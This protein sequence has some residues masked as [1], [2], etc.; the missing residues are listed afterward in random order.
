MAEEQVD[1]RPAEP[2]SQLIPCLV[3][4][5][6]DVS[7]LDLPPLA[8]TA[9]PEALDAVAESSAFVHVRYA[10]CDVT[11]SDGSVTVQDTE[12]GDVAGRMTWSEAADREQS[13][14]EVG[15]RTR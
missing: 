5:L 1:E 15:T 14:A 4:D 10:G 9:D 13:L 6:K 11:I 8:H 12:T 7:P 2:P 3:A